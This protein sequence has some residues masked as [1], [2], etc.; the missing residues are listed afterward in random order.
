MKQRAERI[1]P[2]NPT[3]GPHEPGQAFPGIPPARDA[4]MVST[5][6]RY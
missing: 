2:G 6:T 5:S 3:R 1:E 4:R